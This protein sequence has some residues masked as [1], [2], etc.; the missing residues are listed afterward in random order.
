MLGQITLLGFGLLASTGTGACGYD[1]KV[2]VFCFVVEH[3]NYSR[4]SIDMGTPKTTIV[5][6]AHSVFTVVFVSSSVATC[7]VKLLLHF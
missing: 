6:R 3:D 4:K 2:A 1:H 5:A 7:V